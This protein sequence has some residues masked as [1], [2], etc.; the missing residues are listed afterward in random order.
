MNKRA[1]ILL[2]AVGVILL[3]L[4]FTSKG[5]YANSWFSFGTEAIDL[6]Q[7]VEPAGIAK[8]N[9]STN[10]TDVELVRGSGSADQIQVRLEGKVRSGA[11]DQTKL[12]VEPKGETLSVGVERPRGYNWGFYVPEVT[13]VVELPEKQWDTVKIYTGSG[14]LTAD[15]LSGNSVTAEVRSGDI[16]LTNIKAADL[17]VSASSGDVTVTGLTADEASLEAK[18]GD[19]TAQRY[20]AG[21]LAVHASSGDI[22]LKDGE[23]ALVGE[24]SSGD[25]DI[26]AAGLLHNTDLNAR[27]GDVTVKLSSPPQSLAVDF[28]S[29]SGEG[30][31]QWDGMKY[32]EKNDEENRIKGSFGAGDVKLTVRINSGDFDLQEG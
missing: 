17:N 6:E 24:T 28:E 4:T 5:G 7:T 12:V 1:G 11:A 23:A 18:S 15:E 13:L 32:E 9:V 16:D 31:I 21:R 10:S 2:I 25:I 19:I 26:D 22:K 20:S 14:D 30:R 29:S 8:L 3:V 27:S